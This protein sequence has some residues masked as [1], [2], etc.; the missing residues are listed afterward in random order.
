MVKFLLLFLFT[1]IAHALPLELHYSDGAGTSTL[2]EGATLD[3]NRYVYVPAISASLVTVQWGKNSDSIDGYIVYFGNDITTPNET[4][5]I[6]NT[7]NDPVVTEFSVT[8]LNLLED[9]KGCFRIRSYTNNW[10][11]NGYA[12]S[13]YSEATCFNNSNVVSITY[14]LDG[15][16]IAFKDTNPKGFSFKVSDIPI[17]LHIMTALI[18]FSDGA[19]K[20]RTATFTIATLTIPDPNIPIN[21]TVIKLYP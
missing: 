4:R 1:T 16:E 19:T 10:G 11:G 7:G 13:G 21:V 17:G 3:T 6:L 12:V 5:N 15:N 2:L 9:Q 14:S 18:T 8:S 20:T